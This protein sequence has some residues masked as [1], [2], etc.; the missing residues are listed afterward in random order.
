MRL[1]YNHKGELLT[2]FAWGKTR[3]I[4]AACDVRN[5]LNGDRPLHDPNDRGKVILAMNTDPH[6][7][8][9]VMPRQFPVGTWSIG[10]PVQRSNPYNK[11]LAPF[12]IPTDAEQ[13]LDIW[14]LDENSGYDHPTGEKVLD[15]YYGLHFSMSKTT[16]GCI[17]IINENDCLW[18]VEQINFARISKEE[19]IIS[20]TAE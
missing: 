16:V 17:S 10:R 5:E 18:L 14:A 19:N 20:V 15:M 1:K 7:A 12:Y 2:V 6:T 8:P 3:E 11:Y 4:E 9:P 13:M